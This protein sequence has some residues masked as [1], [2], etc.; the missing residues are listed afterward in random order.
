[1]VKALTLTAMLALAACQT[2]TGDFCDV[3]KPIRLSSA[4]IDTMTDAEVAATL[5]HNRKGAAMCG[6]RA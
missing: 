2:A 3:A 6:W 4:V 1:M 5:S